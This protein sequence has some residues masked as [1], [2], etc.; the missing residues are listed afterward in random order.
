MSHPQEGRKQKE[1]GRRGFGPAAKRLLLFFSFLLLTVCTARSSRREQIKF[2]G[3][4]REGEVVTQMI[5]EFER[6]NPGIHVDVQQ[7]PWTAAHEKLL[8]A[9]VGSA[10]PDVAQMG[11]TWIP[12]FHAIHALD[13]L[14]PRLAGSPIRPDDYFAG[15]WATN[16]VDGQLFGVPWYVDTRVLFYRTDLL[17]KA[18][19]MRAPRT[20]SEWF[21]AMHRIRARNLA[22]FAILLPIN[23]W[24]EPTMFA[25]AQQ[26]TLLRDGGRFGAFSQPEFVRAFSQYI[27]L[28]RKGYAPAVSNTQVANVY[29]GF[30]QGDFAM[31]LSGPWNVGEM[32]ARL[33]PEMQGHWSTAPMPAPD[34]MRWPGASLAGGASLVIF[35]NSAHKDAAWKLIEFLSEPK[36]QIRFFELT[37]DLPANKGAWKTRELT[38][39]PYIA[40]FRK[41]LENVQPLPAVPEWERIATAIYEDGESAIRGR[42][43]VQQAVGDLDRKADEILAKRRWVL[44]RTGGH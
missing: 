42:M 2:W 28:F 38:T 43:T 39:D 8:T 30:A 18:G 9:Y 17:K 5:P 6:L 14:T 40:A 11:N 24:E 23:Q 12:E 1:E 32:R 21:D 44:A 35:R 20:W 22:R 16:D 4:G 27:D 3:L 31:Y 41:Q 13:S 37:K 34:G 25:L 15:I 36:Q 10:T 26:S 7:I 29:Q 33:P 19:V